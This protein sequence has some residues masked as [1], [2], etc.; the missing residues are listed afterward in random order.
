MIISYVR[1]RLH[2]VGILIVIVIVIHHP[3]SRF[4]ALIMMSMMEGLFFC[5]IAQMLGKGE[6]EGKRLFEFRG[7]VGASK[8]G[9]EEGVNV[10]LEEDNLH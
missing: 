5:F 2:H 9:I 3:V 8:E 6:K 1:L 4:A 10:G 7:V